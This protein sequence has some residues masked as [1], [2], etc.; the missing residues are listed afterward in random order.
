MADETYVL[1]AVCNRK[2][3]GVE[4]AIALDP[5]IEGLHKRTCVGCL[6]KGK[7]PHDPKTLRGVPIGECVTGT[8]LDN[9]IFDSQPGTFDERKEHLR[10]LDLDRA[11][12]GKALKF[13]HFYDKPDAPPKAKEEELPGFLT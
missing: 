3:D 4:L 13:A 5:E 12:R 8:Y 10:Q 7:L 2:L 1:C 11:S 9:G 6:R